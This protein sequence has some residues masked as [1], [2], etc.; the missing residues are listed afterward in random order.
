MARPEQVF[1]RGSGAGGADGARARGRARLA[2]GGDALD[3]GE[4]RLLGGDAAEVGA[5]GRGR[6]GPAQ[7]RDDGGAGAAEGARARGSASCG[8]R[9]RSCARRPRFSP[10]RSSTADRSDG[11]VHRRAPRRRTGS[12]RSA[13]CCRSPRR[14]TTSTR[15]ARSDPARLPARRDARRRAARRDRAGLEG[16]LRRSTGRARCGGSSTREGI[17]VARC[18]VERLMRADGP[19]GRGSRAQRSTTTVPDER[20]ARPADLVQRDFSGRPPEPALGRRPDLRGDLGAASSTSPS[21][22]TSSRA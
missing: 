20:A 11:G 18:T 3:R 12:S 16:E 5:A 2:V 14:R 22:S 17:A 9:T 1:T 7:R 8:A 13:R 10:R 21:S 4:D 6:S 15:R 19:A